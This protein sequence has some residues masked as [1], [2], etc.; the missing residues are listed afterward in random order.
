MAVESSPDNTAA[1]ENIKALIKTNFGLEEATLTVKP[2][3]NTNNNKVY[4]VELSSPTTSPV[5]SLLHRPL[6]HPIPPGTSQLVVRRPKT[7]VS[8][9]DSVRVRNE[10]AF[11][12][13]ACEALGAV[14]GQASLCPRV[15]AWDDANLETQ[16]IVEE[17]KYGEHISTEEV[18]AF[19]PADQTH[20]FTQIAK[21]VKALQTIKLPEG[22]MYGGLTFNDDGVISSTKS[23]IPCDGP[24]KTYTEFVKG[25]CVWQLEASERSKHLNGWTGTPKLRERLEAFFANGLDKVL[26]A[27]EEDKPTLTHADLGMFHPSYLSVKLTQKAN[28]DARHGQSAL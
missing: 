22:V 1:M 11:L 16:F 18:S 9:E 3:A 15:Y 17:F 19:S 26:E 24:F 12:S 23:P 4:L 25:M 6:T 5:P 20:I 27:I 28:L 13:L 21:F 14:D 7:N 10:V 8:M 2:M